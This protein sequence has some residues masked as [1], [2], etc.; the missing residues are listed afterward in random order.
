MYDHQDLEYF[1]LG[2]EENWIMEPLTH[3]SSN[4]YRFN[5]IAEHVKGTV[6]ILEDFDGIRALLSSHFKRQGYDVESAAT[7]RGALSL[8]L[9]NT[10]AV[11]FIDYDLS[12]ENP[13]NAI[14][15]LHGA[16]PESR[17]VLIGGPLS[18]LDKERALHAGASKI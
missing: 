16:L 18:A 8:S 12:A 15:V 1:F 10:P 7:L 11:L 9:E 6:L 4:G 17:I 13:Y 2:G 3:Y 14:Q 5:H